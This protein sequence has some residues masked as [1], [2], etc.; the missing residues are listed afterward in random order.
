MTRP[1]TR[2]PRCPR[3]GAV[4]PRARAA[5]R[6]VQKID[7]AIL[8][9]RAQPFS[10]PHTPKPQPVHHLVVQD[11]GQA[12]QGGEHGDAQVG[13]GAGGRGARRRRAAAAGGGTVAA[14]APLAQLAVGGAAARFQHHERDK[15]EVATDCNHAAVGRAGDGVGLEGSVACCRD[16]TGRRVRPCSSVC[17]P[18]PRGGGGTATPRWRCRPRGRRPPR[19][20]RV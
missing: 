5:G 10:S 16:Q 3:P 1:S 14:T 15:A 18:R 13:G 12:A 4:P 7:V 11:G 2:R 6:R 19:R 8:H 17:R 9:P 20:G